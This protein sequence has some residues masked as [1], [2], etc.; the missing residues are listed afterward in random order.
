MD[1]TRTLPHTAADRHTHTVDMLASLELRIPPP[2]L[3]LIAA[4]VMWIGARDTVPN[5]RPPWIT[6]IALGIGIS[7]LLIIAAAILTLRRA[8]TTVSP[9]RPDTSRALVQTGVFSV[10]RNPIYL[11]ATLLLLAFACHL[12]QP[13]SFVAIP[14]F[15]AW[16]H[17][18]QIIPEERVLR[19]TFGEAFEQYTASTRRWI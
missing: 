11:A 4:I 6:P 12:W 14:V 3:S 8:G 2:L 17:R 16:I 1:E 19:A 15:A 10:T 18:F 5:P 7:A 9:T 13:Q